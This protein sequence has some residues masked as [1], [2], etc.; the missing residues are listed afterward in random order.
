MSSSQGFLPDFNILTEIAT[1]TI[2]RQGLSESSRIVSTVWGV[3]HSDIGTSRQ[4]I[5]LMTFTDRHI[6]LIIKNYKYSSQFSIAW[7]NMNLPYHD[8]L[9]ILQMDKIEY[10]REPDTKPSEF[11]VVNISMLIF[12]FP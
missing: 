6:F 4:G 7:R 11:K 5:K 10:V 1:L 3:G 9:D 8:N 12:H 2:D